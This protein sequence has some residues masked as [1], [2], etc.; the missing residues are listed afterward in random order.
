MVGQLVLPVGAARATRFPGRRRSLGAVPGL[1]GPPPARKSGRATPADG[2]ND[3]ATPRKVLNVRLGGWSLRSAIRM[4]ANVTKR[5]VWSAK[6]D[7]FVTFE[8]LRQV[9]RRESSRTV[10]EAPQQSQQ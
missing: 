6:M 7:R 1:G 4:L 3:Q 8:I 2:E 10:I 5:L 9:D